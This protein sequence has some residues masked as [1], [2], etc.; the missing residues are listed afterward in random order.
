[1]LRRPSLAVAADLGAGMPQTWGT[2]SLSTTPGHRSGHRLV[3]DRA[4]WGVTASDWKASTAFQMRTD[5]DQ[6]SLLSIRLDGSARTF[7]PR[8]VGSTPTGPTQRFPGWRPF[9]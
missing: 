4:A 1:M 9:S 2:A 7:N 8:V 6:T 5:P 3:T